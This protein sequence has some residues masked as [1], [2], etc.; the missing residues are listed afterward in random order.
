M[1]PINTNF[2]S[3]YSE[4]LIKLCTSINIYSEDRL[5]IHMKCG[6]HLIAITG[7]SKI[8]HDQLLAALPKKIQ[9]DFL[10]G[11]LN[12]KKYTTIDYALSRKD[13][14]IYF[15]YLMP[16]EL[17]KILVESG[18]ESYEKFISFI[19]KGAR[20]ANIPGAK[21]NTE[22]ELYSYMP[23]HIRGWYRRT[24]LLHIEQRFST[25]SKKNDYLDHTFLSSLSVRARNMA[26]AHGLFNAKHFDS[27]F[28]QQI[29]FN[30]IRGFGKGL[31][32]EFRS[33]L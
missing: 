24:H 6:M 7:S 33:I 20:L 27:A 17:Y 19:S 12:L 10:E 30:K 28:S 26:I 2:P 18:I 23:E 21:H 15:T 11:T 14:E 3:H 1:L 13:Q 31:I 32:K 9:K 16:N 8:L 25:V 5:I 22:L 4:Q 29:N